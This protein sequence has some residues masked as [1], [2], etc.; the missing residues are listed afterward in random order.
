MLPRFSIGVPRVVSSSAAACPRRRGHGWVHDLGVRVS[1]AA[2]P[3]G[4]LVGV[5]DKL[6]GDGTAS[7]RL[8]ASRCG[9]FVVA[10]ARGG[11]GAVVTGI[12]VLRLHRNEV[13]LAETA[14]AISSTLGR[15][16]HDM[17]VCTCA[18]VCLRCV[19]VRRRRD[20][21]GVREA[22]EGI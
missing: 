13:I 21:E 22:R 7:F 15:V 4:L 2:P 5:I 1:P 16:A 10:I 18:C 12:D 17:C 20:D 6:R 8:M 19:V 9:V 14:V 3:R 11:L